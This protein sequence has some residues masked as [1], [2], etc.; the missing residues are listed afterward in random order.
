LRKIPGGNNAD[1]DD[2]ST[3]TDSKNSST[4]NTNSSNKGNDLGESK[5]ID[6]FSGNA[7]AAGNAAKGVGDKNKWKDVPDMSNIWDIVDLLPAEERRLV[8]LRV[9]LLATFPEYFA[10]YRAKDYDNDGKPN[11]TKMNVICH[12][13]TL[14]N[15]HGGDGH[16]MLSRFCV[17]H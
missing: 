5:D 6:C 8:Q 2:N 3:F 16:L 13:N 11:L 15:F 14:K 10:S 12:N 7:N 9:V 4:N 17:G 1:Q